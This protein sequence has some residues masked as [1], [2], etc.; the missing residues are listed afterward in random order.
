MKCKMFKAV[1]GKD[2][3][4][5]VQDWLDANPDVKI[6]HVTQSNEGGSV[7]NLSIFYTA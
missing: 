7:V 6:V 2:L 5:E 3:E 1:G 4:T